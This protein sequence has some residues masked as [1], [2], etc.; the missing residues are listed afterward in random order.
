MEKEGA[1]IV[2]IAHSDDKRQSTA[3]LTIT[4]AGEYLPPQ[5]LYQGKTPKCHPQI[6]FLT[7]W[8]VWHS[9]NHWSN[10]ITMKHYIDNIIAPFVL[11]FNHPA[12]AI[13]DNFRGQTTVNILSHLKSHNIVPLQLPANCIDKL[14]PLDIS[15]NKPM[16][17]Y[18]EK[19]FQQWYALEVKTQLETVPLSEVKV[20]V[21]LQVVKC[22]S[23]NWIIYGWQELEER[24]EVAVN[25]FKKSGIFAIKL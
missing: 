8:D 3:V 25:S 5:L 15:V 14:Q 12:I 23:A 21:S 10:E 2:P 18:P 1:K 19:R 17:D 20:D 24:S 7:G 16:K 11:R 4:V 13:F 22:P 9:H 6:S